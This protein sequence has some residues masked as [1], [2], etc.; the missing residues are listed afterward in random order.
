MVVYDIDQIISIKF[1]R[2]NVSKKPL[3]IQLT[4]RLKNSIYDNKVYTIV[5]L[6]KTLYSVGH[7]AHN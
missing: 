2:G 7:K 1:T 4:K 3:T 6:S 5:D